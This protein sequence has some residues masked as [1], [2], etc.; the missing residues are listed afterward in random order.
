MKEENEGGYYTNTGEYIPKK[1][2]VID[3]DCPKCRRTYEK[4]EIPRKYECFCGNEVAPPNHPWLIP[5]SCGETCK[6]AL[7]PAC[8]HKCVLL[9]HPGPC[10][11]CP[12]MITTSCKCKQ[13]NLKTIR[14]SLQSWTCLRKVYF[15]CKLSPM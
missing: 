15:S 11:P 7:T 8:G 6:K 12:Q 13:S 10:P 3:W 14:C 1:S 2:R 4:D 5:H 9:C